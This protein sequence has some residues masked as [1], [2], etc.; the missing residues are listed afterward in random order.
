MWLSGLLAIL[1]GCAQAQAKAVFAH[2]MVSWN[3]KVF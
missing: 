1:L 2:F 3:F